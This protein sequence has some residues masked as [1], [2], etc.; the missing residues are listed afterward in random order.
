MFPNQSPADQIP[1]S[2]EFLSLR[3]RPFFLVVRSK[4]KRLLSQARIIKNYRW[5]KQTRIYL[6]HIFFPIL[7]VKLRKNIHLLPCCRPSSWPVSILHL[8]IQ[9]FQSDRE[10]KLVWSQGGESPT[11]SRSTCTKWNLILIFP[12]LNRC[13]R[14]NGMFLNIGCKNNLFW[15]SLTVLNLF[16]F[17]LW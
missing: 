13:R 5:Q 15:T 3:R 1:D 9:N 12:A 16:Q 8:R 6:W 2:I 14:K 17:A 7:V 4:E 10:L 11:E